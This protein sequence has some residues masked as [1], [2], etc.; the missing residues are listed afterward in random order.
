MASS[1]RALNACKFDRFHAVLDYCERVVRDQLPHDMQDPETDGPFMDSCVANF[2]SKL[3]YL[4][5][6]AA[7]ATTPSF[8]RMILSADSM[9][10]VRIHKGSKE[11][12]RL[13][14]FCCDACKR[15]EKNCT[16]AIDV[17]GSGQQDTRVYFNHVDRI[18]DHFKTFYADYQARFDAYAEG[19]AVCDYGRF[20][21]GKTC[22]RKAKLQFIFSTMIQ[23]M[24]YVMQIKKAELG[25]DPEGVLQTAELLWVNEEVVQSLMSRMEDLE[26]CVAD[27]KR[28]L[29][30]L[31]IDDNFWEMIDIGREEEAELQKEEVWK[32]LKG[33]SA[34]TM[35]RFEDEASAK[36]V[37]T[38]VESDDD[39]LA[40]LSPA[41]SSHA[42]SS[43]ASSSVHPHDDK[44]Q[45]DDEKEGRD[46]DLVDDEEKGE[47]DVEVGL[48][49]VSRKR[50]RAVVIEDED[51]DDDGG[52]GGGKGGDS[53]QGGGGR[54]GRGGRGGRGGGG[55]NGGGGGGGSHCQ[56]RRRSSRHRKQTRFYA[57]EEEEELDEE[58]GG[59]ER[60]QNE[61]EPEHEPEREN[62]DDKVEEEEEEEEEEREEEG[63][64]VPQAMQKR[65]ARSLL[66]PHPL[67]AAPT[68][69]S[70]ATSL[71]IRNACDDGVRLGSRKRA[72]LDLI[73]VQR[74]LV[75]DDMMD[76][77]AKLSRAILTMQELLD[78]QSK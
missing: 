65:E 37:D 28:P 75:Q 18:P 2:G 10:V 5:A 13:E 11:F 24:L 34:H 52:G 23:E 43:P 58:E 56:T 57:R 51:E 22:L 78:L 41:S 40:S 6:R 60:E 1:G 70:I 25:D 63:E 44:E 50:N 17:A 53:Q 26:L 31:E 77:A 4:Q 21:V 35:R 3:H 49:R 45:P 48:S 64:R 69:A 74:A 46:G 61:C 14:H 67:A 29:E 54:S 68:A 76:H 47:D 62:V 39:Q 32:V 9:R 59:G 55:R 20:Y 33:R 7:A 36:G 8:Q 72:L 73:D 38:E 16:F 66:R 12:K 19:M 30:D 71:R 42:S 27:E 15:K